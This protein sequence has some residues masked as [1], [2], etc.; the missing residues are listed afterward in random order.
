MRNGVKYER[1]GFLKA[2]LKNLLNELNI[3]D[4]DEH[5]LIIKTQLTYVVEEITDIVTGHIYL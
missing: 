2:E 4:D 1:L 3:T 5:K